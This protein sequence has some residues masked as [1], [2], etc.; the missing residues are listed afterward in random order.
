MSL[1]I[2]NNIDGEHPKRSIDT[3]REIHPLILE[4]KRLFSEP[5]RY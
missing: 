2:S 5:K 4:H 1:I 3:P